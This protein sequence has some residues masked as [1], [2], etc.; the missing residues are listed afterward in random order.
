MPVARELSHLSKRN[1]SARLRWR[2]NECLRL[3]RV[4]TPSWVKEQG[5]LVLGGGERLHV[6]SGTT[7][8]EM[9]A[10][11]CC[12]PGASPAGRIN[13]EGLVPADKYGPVGGLRV[14]GASPLLSWVGWETGKAR[15]KSLILLGRVNT[16]QVSSPDGKPPVCFPI[17]STPLIHSFNPPCLGAWGRELDA[18][19]ED[20]IAGLIELIRN[21]V[22]FTRFSFPVP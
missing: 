1:V 12:L 14:G 10:L 3:P 13:K 20:G 2:E 22:L 15:T 18:G 9:L 5:S 6:N 17:Y 11:K 8:G 21:C 16:S 4:G 19:E 7:P